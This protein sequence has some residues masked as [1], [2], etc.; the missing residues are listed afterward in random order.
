MPSILVTGA[1][2]YI[3]NA[4]VHHLVSDGSKVRAFDR[5][6]G[7]MSGDQNV[8]FVV[9]DVLDSKS[10]AVALEG[11]DTVFHLAAIISIAG[12]PDGS[13]R[14]VNVE[15]VRNVAEACLDAGVTRMVHCSSV[16]AFDIQNEIDEVTEDSR[17]ANGDDHPAYDRSK[18]EGEEVLRGA[19]DRGLDAVI[20]NPTGVV[21]PPD[22]GPSRMG[23]VFLAMWKRRLPA[24]IAGAFDWV[25]V[26]DVAAVLAAAARR[27]RTGE[28]Y[29]AAGHRHT[30]RD[31]ARMAQAVSG[32][33]TARIELPVGVARALAP[34]AGPIGKAMGTTPL[35]TEESI[36][37]LTL[38]AEVSGSKAASDLGHA[39]R[40]TEVTIADWHEWFLAHGFL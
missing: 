12:D 35:F 29:L 5:V 8:E 40:A 11:I 28:N 32:T 10:T 4:L 19:I 21:G 34:L 27:G 36:N 9:G 26:R 22:F 18:A 38:Q 13:V 2:G 15:G 1:S 23:Q 17:R 7:P 39:P 16:H 25:D 14:R 20:V 3:G 24:T 33:R 30:M 6:A 31:M 37:A